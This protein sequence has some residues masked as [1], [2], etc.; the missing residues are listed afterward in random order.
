MDLISYG[1]TKKHL[2]LFLGALAACLFVPGGDASVDGLSLAVLPALA[3]IMGTAATAAAAGLAQKGAGAIG[4]AIA[5]RKFDKTPAGKARAAIVTSAAR[6]ASATAGELMPEEAATQKAVTLALAHRRAQRREALAA[7]GGVT[8]KSPVQSGIGAAKADAM[9]KADAEMAANVAG[10]VHSVGAQA[11]TA[12]RAAAQ[13]IVASLAKEDQ[14]NMTEQGEKFGEA[15]AAALL[16]G[17][18]KGRDLYKAS[19]K[20]DP[21][22]VVAAGT[23]TGKR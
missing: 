5:K 13:S 19:R 9:R 6:D 4:S 16:A 23:G 22:T 18:L 3:T 14:E 17:G 12:R 1:L 21:G 20:L 10:Q 8:P 15:G 7:N 2:F 11:A